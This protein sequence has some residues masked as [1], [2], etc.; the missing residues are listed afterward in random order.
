MILEF[1]HIPNSVM[2]QVYDSYSFNIIPKLGKFVANDSESY[3]YLVE[4][5]RKFPKQVIWLHY[6][7]F[8]PRFIPFS[9]F[10]GEISMTEISFVLAD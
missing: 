7:F 5:I 4:S 9:V 6:S 3:Q 8:H 1:S 10:F 2:Q